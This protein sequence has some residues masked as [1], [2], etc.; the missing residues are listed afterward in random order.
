MILIEF[1]ID[2]RLSIVGLLTLYYDTD[3]YYFVLHLGHIPRPLHVGQS[4]TF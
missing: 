1:E 2:S 3:L 4:T